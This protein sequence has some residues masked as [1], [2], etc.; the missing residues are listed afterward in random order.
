MFIL[1][2]MFIWLGILDIYFL[3][4]ILKKYVTDKGQLKASL[5]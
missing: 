1:E 2:H 3:K 4:W 5:A